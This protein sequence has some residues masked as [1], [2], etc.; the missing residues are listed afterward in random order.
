MC[1]AQ[2]S[3]AAALLRRTWESQRAASWIW[4]SNL[5]GRKDDQPH[6]ELFQQK[7][8]QG[9]DNSAL[10]S[11]C[12]TVSKM[13]FW[14]LQYKKATDSLD[15]ILYRVLK[16]LISRD[17]L[18]RG[19]LLSVEK[20]HLSRDVNSSLP[21]PDL[22]WQCIAGENRHKPKQECFRSDVKKKLFPVSCRK[23]SCQRGC[24]VSI[25]RA[26]QDLISQILEEPTLS[27]NQD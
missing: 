11:A 26:F 10:L 24:A 22:S 3:W 2:T 21:A 6:P 15:K 23:T 9:H 14:T 27:R 17:R 1:W 18:R 7:H 20:R 8:S 4:A 25:L 16:H 5:P 19:S 12:W 13:K